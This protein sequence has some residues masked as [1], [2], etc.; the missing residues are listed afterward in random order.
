MKISGFYWCLLLATSFMSHAQQ[1]PVVSILKRFELKNTSIRAIEVVNDSTVWFA[2]SN[3]KYGRIINDIVEIDSVRHEGRFPHFRSIAFNGKHI[4]LLSIEDPALLYKIDP[5]LPLGNAALVYK[6]SHAKVFY[7]SMRFLDRDHGMA[8]G[9]PV[10]NCLSVIQ[11]TDAGEHWTKLSC[12]LLPEVHEG[13]AAFAASNTNLALIG[14]KIWIAT[15]GKKARVLSAERPYE[16]WTSTETPIVQGDQMTGI[17]TIDFYDK[18]LGIIMGGNWNDKKNGS[19]S[20]AI[21]HDGGQTWKLTGT[22]EVPGFISCVQFVPGKSGKEILAV[23]TEGIYFSD[24]MAGTWVK[25]D[26]KGYYSLRF[27]DAKTFWCSGDQEIVKIK[28]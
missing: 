24:D 2:G 19:R 14:N 11:T 26:N 17:F 4:F 1:T 13:E 5:S 6:E 25:I 23:S 27:A 9:D 10:E 15:G 21:S 3:G 7:D 18:N 16:Q 22:D 20:K 28:I 8:I 12:D